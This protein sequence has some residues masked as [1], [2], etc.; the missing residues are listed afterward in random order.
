MAY[1]KL[2]FILLLIMSVTSLPSCSSNRAET[3]RLTEKYGSELQAIYLQ[4]DAGM[5]QAC[6]KKTI[7]PIQDIV[8][9]DRLEA[10]KE[11]ILTY[12]CLG[13]LISL[14]SKLESFHAVEYTD[15]HA[16]VL[17]SEALLVA[18]PSTPVGTIF[19]RT[20]FFVKVDGTWK[21]DEFNI[22]VDRD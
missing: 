11:G 13:D 14:P 7:T 17:M 15:Q 8:S 2:K 12:D 6:D 1:R 5:E 10:I 4:F 18:T 21:I 3:M 16:K 9:P 22:P 19:P 20:L